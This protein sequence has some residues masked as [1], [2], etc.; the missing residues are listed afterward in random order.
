[1][2]VTRL[3]DVVIPEEFT[4][5]TVQNSMENSA[6][7]QSGVAARNGEIEAQLRAGAESFSVP[8]WNDLSDDEADIVSDDPDTSSTPAKLGSGK[9]IVR[10]S[11]LHKSW[12]A[13]NLASELSGDDA[14][15]RIQ[16]RT[17]AYWTRQ[18]QRR[19]IGSLN[20]ILGDNVAN[21]SGDMLQDITAETGAANK[22]SVAAVIDAAGTL[23][24]QMGGL[25]AMGVHS[26]TYKVILKSDAIEYVPD[27]Q[28]GMIATYRGMALIVDDLLPVLTGDYTSVLFGA[29]A[30]GWGMTAPRIAEGTEI[31]SK[32]SAGNGGGQQVLHSRVNLAMHP[33]G[34]AWQ[35]S[36]VVGDSATIAELGE[37]T[38][39]NRVVERRAVPLAFL[40]HKL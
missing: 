3:S 26:D 21:D 18:A 14:L 13:M 36:S 19:L 5:Y 12:S 32:P 22:F 37:A 6:L 24:D 27:S 25:S 28:G 20:G 34:F 33:A 1:M 35:E 11:F 29:G 17:T 15:T 31:E 2:A 9:Q 10:K 4:T 30:V 16:N 23:G 7:V 40:K 8:F 38:N 39:W